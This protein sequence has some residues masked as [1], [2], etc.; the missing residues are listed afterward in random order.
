MSATNWKKIVIAASL[1]I[2]GIPSCV[3]M[4][5]ICSQRRGTGERVEMVQLVSIARRV[6]IHLHITGG[7]AHLEPGWDFEDALRGGCEDIIAEMRELGIS[8]NTSTLASVNGMGVVFVLI[9][10]R[11]IGM[12]M[13]D[14]TFVRIRKDDFEV[15]GKDFR[16][17]WY[18]VSGEAAILDERSILSPIRREHQRN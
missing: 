17:W 1:V 15:V 2:L 8:A 9:G 18:P 3:Y 13:R 10:P 16:P 5:I 12:A 4:A 6:G 7:I 14:G 11:F